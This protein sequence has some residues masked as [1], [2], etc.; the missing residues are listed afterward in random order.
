MT[1]PPTRRQLV[2]SEA[3]LHQAAPDLGALSILRFGEALAGISV[4]F[5][6]GAAAGQLLAGSDASPYLRA[7]EEL[8]SCALAPQE[9][10]A[11]PRQI[12]VS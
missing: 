8:R 12:A 10:G 6:P 7:W 2:I 5:V 9:S 1:A 3:A 11:L 4:A